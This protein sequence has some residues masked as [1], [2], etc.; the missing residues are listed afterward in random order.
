MAQALMV[1]FLAKMSA[2]LAI[3]GNFWSLCLFMCSSYT[4]FSLFFQGKKAVNYPKSS[5]RGT[6]KT[7]ISSSIKRSQHGCCS[8]LY[9]H[10]VRYLSCPKNVCFKVSITHFVIYHF[11]AGKWDVFC[12]AAVCF[13][14]YVDDVS[15]ARVD[16]IVDDKCEMEIDCTRPFKGFVFSWSLFAGTRVKSLSPLCLEYV[17]A[18]KNFW[19][20]RHNG[21]L[22][23]IWSILYMLYLQT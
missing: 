18:R 9:C 19:G 6:K 20:A 13:V 12:F 2:N 5:N 15:A 7:S 1:T 11:L 21:T 10:Y 17:K 4:K 8:R 14:V 16:I 22:S 23:K 3:N